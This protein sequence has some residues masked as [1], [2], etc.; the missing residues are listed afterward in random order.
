MT[1]AQRQYQI[2]FHTAALGFLKGY[3]A[4]AAAGTTGASVCPSRKNNPHAHVGWL[5][6]DHEARQGG[7]ENA[8]DIELFAQDEADEVSPR[9]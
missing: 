7:W 2:V 4:R 1:D 5:K 3:R 9:C 8:E 6:A